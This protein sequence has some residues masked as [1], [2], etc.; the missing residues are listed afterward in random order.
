MI[1]AA[2]EER[3]LE[4]LAL[5][6]RV[7]EEV[8]DRLAK[9]QVV[10][11][12]HPEVVEAPADDLDAVELEDRAGDV[13]HVDHASL[14]IEHDEAVLARLEDLL[15]LGLFL[16]HDVDAAALDRDR[17]LPRHGLQ[18]LALVERQEA[19]LL[20]GAHADHADDPARGRERNVEPFAAGQRLR[21]RSGLLVVAPHPGGRRRLGLGER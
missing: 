20:R 8:A 12:P 17:R 11:M 9:A 19:A 13:V 1:P 4:P 16:E 2:E 15:G 3:D 18:E 7:F 10:G 21:A 6:V 5:P 14:G